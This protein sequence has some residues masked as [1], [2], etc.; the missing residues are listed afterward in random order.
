MLKPDYRPLDDAL[1]E[2]AP[3]GIALTNGNFNH[4]PMAVEA[5][6]ALGRPDAVE[7]WL[8]RYRERMLPREAAGSRIAADDWRGNLGRRERFADWARFF[9]E[10]LEEAPWHSVLHNW[11]ARLAPGFCAAATHGVIRVGHAARALRERETPARRRELGDALASWA[12]TWQ[13]LPAGKDDAGGTLPPAEAI[14]RVP[15]LPAERRRAGNITARLEALGDM[16]EFA[17]AAALLDTSGPPTATAAEAAA[18]F[19]LVYLANARDIGTTIAFIHAV[20]SHAALDTLLRYLGETTA[21][22]AV[23]YAWQAGCG[24]YAC[25][26]G[27]TAMAEAVEAG[28]ADPDRLA[29]AAVAHGDEHAIKFTEACLRLYADDPFPAYLAAA[30]HVTGMLRPK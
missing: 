29:E 6:C 10:R 17:P 28:D 11:V 9:G 21:R 16:P 5:L 7:P 30:A 13:R 20:T 18:V 15:L 23:R 3:F 4:A 14:L 24:L 1:D 8:Q 2:I 25:Y 12:A 22:E 27:T 26:G 19:A